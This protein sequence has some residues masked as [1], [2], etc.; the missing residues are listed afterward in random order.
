[1]KITKKHHLLL[2]E[3]KKKEGREVKA[4]RISAVNGRLIVTKPPLTLKV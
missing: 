3:K 2:F 1:M 4:K